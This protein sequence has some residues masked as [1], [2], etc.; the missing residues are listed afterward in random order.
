MTESEN[1]QSPKAAAAEE[2]GGLLQKLDHLEDYWVS[3]KAQL[4]ARKPTLCS[5]QSPPSSSGRNKN[6]GASSMVENSPPSLTASLQLGVGSAPATGRWKVRTNDLAV[7][8]VLL[9]R[10]A[11]IVDGRL[12]GRRLFHDD[13]PETEDDD[14]VTDFVDW[15]GSHP[16]DNHYQDDQKGTEEEGFSPDS[17]SSS[18]SFVCDECLKK[19]AVDVVRGKDREDTTA[20]AA[21][22]LDL[23]PAKHVIPEKRRSP[24]SSLIAVSQGRRWKVLLM[25]CLA[26]GVVVV[27]EFF[28]DGYGNRDLVPT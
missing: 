1:E 8:E 18:S 25:V 16:D 4:K 22:T 27:A 17:S 5:N 20:A 26:I 11:A 23:V 6:R 3:R 21:T 28:I 13:Q 9:E 24:P 15:Y 14:D 10:R 7:E 19:A 12:K 2:E